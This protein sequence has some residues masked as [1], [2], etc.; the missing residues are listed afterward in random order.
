MGIHK[1]IPLFLKKK[2]QLY[3]IGPNLGPYP[4]SHF[5][6]GGE[7]IIL[8]EILKGYNLLRSDGFF[9]DVGAYHPFNGSNTY[10]LYKLGWSG[11]NIEAR[12]GSKKLFDECRPLDIN[13]EMGVT[14]A[15]EILTYYYISES[16]PMNSFSKKYLDEI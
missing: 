2:I 4:L 9:V 16:S 14:L 10:E 6:Q 12:P 15:D 7:D 8:M 5:S 3:L 1:F 11:I 13:L